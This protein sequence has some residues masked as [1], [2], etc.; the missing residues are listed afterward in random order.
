MPAGGSPPPSR[1]RR[2]TPYEH[3]R[4]CRC[5]SGP[6]ST[7]VGRSDPAPRDARVR[8]PQLSAFGL[9]LLVLEQKGAMTAYALARSGP[10]GSCSSTSTPS[11]AASAASPVQARTPVELRERAEC[12]LPHVAGR[13]APDGISSA[14][15]L[16][17]GA[18]GRNRSI[19][20]AFGRVAASRR[21]ARRGGSRCRSRIEVPARTARRPRGARRPP[22][23]LVTR[24]PAPDGGP[25]RRRRRPRRGARAARRSG[26]PSGGSCS[27]ASALRW[28]RLRR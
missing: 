17:F 22:G 21:S 5:R 28:S 7:L 13:R 2:G 25:R 27:A 23:R 18:R 6:A 9:I 19:I 12:E 4:S 1:D 11:A 3:L 8:S 20:Q 16:G 15:S 24:R 14:L 10:G 26:V